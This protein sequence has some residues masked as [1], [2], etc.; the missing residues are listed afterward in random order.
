MYSVYMYVYIHFALEYLQK[1][2]YCQ[3]SDFKYFENWRLG[4]VY[5]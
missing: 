4:L 5:N 2:W 1:Q 3:D